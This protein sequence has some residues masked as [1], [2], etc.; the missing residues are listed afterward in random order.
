MGN[1]LQSAAA[2]LSPWVRAA[3]T[4]FERLDCLAHQ[5]SGSGSAYFG[6]CRHARHARRVASILR[7]R[8]LGAV[9]AVRS[10]P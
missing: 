10:F 6:L 1:S 2:R 8:Q 9:Y 3:K 5:L 7:V 4:A